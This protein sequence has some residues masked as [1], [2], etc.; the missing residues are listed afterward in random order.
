MSNYQSSGGI[1][2]PRMAT[3]ENYK[4]LAAEVIIKAADDYV[5]AYR[6]ALK[7][8]NGFE[9]KSAE[10]AYKKIEKFFR[11]E[12]FILYSGGNLDPEV[13]LEA[14]RKKARKR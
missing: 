6:M 4:R 5:E 8:K 12:K 2:D 14:L 9:H 13:V 11:S 10:G 7:K 1:S 3:L